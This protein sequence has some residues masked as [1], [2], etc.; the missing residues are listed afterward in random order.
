MKGAG[1]RA[2]TTCDG[3]P[4]RPK[5]KW[6]AVIVASIARYYG[7]QALEPSVRGFLAIL[8]KQFDRADAYVWELLQNG[9]D[10][11]ATQVVVE[12]LSERRGVRVS[13]DG[14][15]FTPLDVLGLSSV[16]LSTKS[17]LS[18]GNAPRSIGFM[19]IG[20]K[21]VYRRFKRVT[22][23]DGRWRFRYDEPRDRAPGEPK[24]AWVLRPAPWSS[25]ASRRGA[26][27]TWSGR[28]SP[29]RPI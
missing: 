11:G 3:V 13:H 14:R 8:E 17:L 6:P 4:P 15:R 18:D 27:S 22:V 1:R 26:R 16:G 19:G 20:F 9:V 24:H 7:L 25:T 2:P 12:R 5:G 23:S 21:A 10:D 28:A 29:S